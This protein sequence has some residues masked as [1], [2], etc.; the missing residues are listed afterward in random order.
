MSKSPSEYPAPVSKPDQTIA[1]V[2]R[3]LREGRTSC[4]KILEGCLEQVDEWEPKVHAWV[5]LDRDKALEQAAS[6][7]TS[8]RPATTA[9]RCMG[10]RSESKT[11]STSPD[12][13]RLAAR[14]GGRIGIA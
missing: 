12:C 7:T 13:R 5:I 11:S 8:S 10:F 1:G 4:V 6:W 9:G 2:G 3:A 14:S